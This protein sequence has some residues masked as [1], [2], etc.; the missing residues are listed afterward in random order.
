VALLRDGGVAP[1]RS[2]FPPYTA[3][4]WTSI[5]TGVGPGRHGV[6]GFTDAD[7]HAVSDS[8]VAAPRLW[9]YVGTAGGR[10]VVVNMPITHPPRT[11]DGVLVSGM[12]VPPGMAYTAPLDTAAALE[13]AGYFVDVAVREDAQESPATLEKLRAMTLARGAAVVRLA[14]TEAWDLFVAVFVLPDRLGHPWWKY[15]VAGDAMFDTATGARVR[16]GARE[17]LVALDRAVTDLVA[18]MPANAAIVACS[19]HG[20]GTLRADVF[21]DVALAEAG[22]ISTRSGAATLGRLGR[23]RIG[24][25][26]PAAVRRIGRN[27]AASSGG[28]AAWTA[29]PYECGVRLGDPAVAGAVTE[30]LMGLRDPDG[31]PLVSAVHRRA[32]LYDG[33]YVERAPDLL[34]EVA[35]E[36][37]DLHDGAHAPQPWV[38]RAELPWG[39]HRV[40]GIVAISGAP[41]TGKGPS[42]PLSGRRREAPDIASTVL[43]LLGLDVEGLDGSSLVASGGGHQVVEAAVA[44]TADAVY[45]DEEEAAVLEHLKGLGYVD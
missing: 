29:T 1:L 8:S 16:A 36:S 27:A 2:T 35:D 43:D 42:G 32:D 34:V 39:T 12:P 4:A 10:S 18:A 6:F 7:G 11:I 31:L 33:P 15:L 28:A 5:T 23:S 25:R 19:D 26:L 44:S 3:P 37:V 13:A 38:S 20:F 30:L 24:R 41:M 22:I 9:D 17:S 21:F 45:S 14:T 40:D